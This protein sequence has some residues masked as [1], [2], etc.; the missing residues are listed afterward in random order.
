LNGVLPTSGG[1]RV[2]GRGSEEVG[3]IDDAVESAVDGG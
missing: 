3:V 1:Y 2:L